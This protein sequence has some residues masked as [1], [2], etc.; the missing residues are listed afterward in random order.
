MTTLS[1]LRGLAF[2]AAALAAVTTTGTAQAADWS[3][4]EIQYQYGRLDNPFAGTKDGTHIV[5]LQH[6]SG[7]SFGDVFFFVDFLDDG[8]TDATNFNDK[9]AYGEFYAYFSSAKIFGRKYGGPIKDIGLV[10]GI[11]YDADVGYT[12]YLPGVYIDWAAP[13]F[14]FLRTQFTAIIDDSDIAQEDGFQADVSW[15]YP[16][17][18]SGQLFSFEGHAEYTVNSSNIFGPQKDWF[19]TQPQLRWDVGYAV[20]GKKDQFFIGTEYQYWANKLGT[21]TDE[22]AFQALGVWRF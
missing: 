10:A 11:N 18:I 22:S 20:T 1:K 21:N 12:G 15:A 19:L 3:N 13:G 4:T 6:A 9:D 2:G 5:T 14:A 8:N 16:F 7:Y 17:K